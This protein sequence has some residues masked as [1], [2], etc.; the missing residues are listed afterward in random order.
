MES[1]NFLKWDLVYKVNKRLEFSTG[2]NVKYGQYQMNEKLDADTLFS[3][4]Y[5]NLNLEQYN[6]LINYDNYYDL[7][8]Q[9]QIY[10]NSMNFFNLN[11]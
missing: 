5:P 8:E 7:I 11:E 1:D 10:E 4:N 9:N 2:I 6:D 3:Y